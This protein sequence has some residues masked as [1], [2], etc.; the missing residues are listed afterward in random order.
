MYIIGIVVLSEQIPSS[1][2]SSSFADSLQTFL[3][4]GT[5]VGV[6]LLQY[7]R[8]NANLS[9]WLIISLAGI[10]LLILVATP[11]QTVV[12]HNYPQLGAGQTTPVQLALLPPAKPA[13]IG[14]END[15]KEVEIVIPLGVSGIADDTIVE[16]KGV[17]VTIEA[18]DG[19]R[20]NSGWKS[21]GM[22]LYQE[23]KSTEVRFELK[24]S[25]FDRVKSSPVKTRIALALSVF[26]DGHKR[27]FVTPDGEFQMPDVGLCVGQSGYSRTIHCL[28]PLR[29]PSLLV[30]AD[31]S[32]N[33]CPVGEGESRGKVG[34]IAHDWKQ[35][36]DSTPAEFGISPIREV[37][38]YIWSAP[39]SSTRPRTTAG[40]CP[41]TPLTLSNPKFVQ[42]MRTEVEI[43]ALRLDEYKVNNQS[44]AF[45]GI[46]I[47]Q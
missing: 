1:S 39:G 20:W 8:R 45:G 15:N 27:R 33:T 37:E 43:D 12:A 6:V 16:V 46:A 40:I 5:C 30:T 17:M 14:R 3:L 32:E 9:R 18:S 44:F 29:P 35:N 10:L 42:P 4:I 23:Q 24:K 13:V 38:F 28:A 31:L 19:T 22:I 7:A 41:G 47:K 2:F 11:Y 25:L 21:G 26:R 36:F 34:E